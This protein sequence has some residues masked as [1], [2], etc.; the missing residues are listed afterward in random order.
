MKTIRKNCPICHKDFNALLREVNRGNAKV[1]S[2]QCA[3]ISSAQKNKK[4][5][6]PNTEC[7][8]CKKPFYKEP[9]KKN[10]S[11]SGLYFCCREHKDAA[12][13]IESGFTDIWPNH[14]KSGSSIKYR[15][16]ALAHYG[17]Y[18]QICGYNK[19]PCVLQVHHKDNN[20]TN[21]KLE[22]LLVCCPNCHMEQH[23]INGKVSTKY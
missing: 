7:S 1:C 13:R 16:F 12:Q 14:Y 3:Y 5:H 11:K 23:I 6:I 18:C 20:R 2:R 10:G 19:H 9:S 15:K 21:N 22:N 8:Y 4:T 17:E